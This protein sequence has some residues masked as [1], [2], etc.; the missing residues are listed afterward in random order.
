[1]RDWKP[2]VKVNNSDLKSVLSWIIF[3]YFKID[4][5]RQF[6]IIYVLLVQSVYELS[7]CIKAFSTLVHYWITVHIKCFPTLFC[8]VLW[9]KDCLLQ[10]CPIH[11]TSRMVVKCNYTPIFS[12]L[13]ILKRYSWYSTHAVNR[14]CRL[15][16]CN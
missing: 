11:M 8:D 5:S 2:L 13:I 15:K 1:M 6:N 7:K 4:N 16:S 10:A 14:A 12:L 3:N 9:G